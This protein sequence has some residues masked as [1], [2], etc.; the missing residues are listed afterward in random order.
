MGFMKVD[1][2]PPESSFIV[3]TAEEQRDRWIAEKEHF[4]EEWP[5]Y[6]NHGDD[7]YP[8][9]RELS[10]RHGSLQF[11]I[12]DEVQDIAVARGRTTPFC[13]DGT[14]DDLPTGMDA[15]ALRIDQDEPANTLSALAAEVAA[16]HRNRGLSALVIQVMA[17]LAGRAHLSS[18]VAPVRPNWKDRYPLIPIE[19][20][21]Q[22]RRS[23]GLPFDPW[24][25]VHSRLGATI[26]RHEQRSMGIRGSVEEWEGWTEMS[27]PED[28][29]YTFPF[30]LAPLDVKD[31]QGSYWEPNVWMQHPL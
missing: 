18:F 1:C 11:L 26:L 21:A 16:E 25:R 29:T 28:G 20:Y 22:W 8:L 10:L 7:S 5:E 15:L 3:I 12:V 2:L 30:G 9:F 13:W 6:N 14:L 19:Q 27:F 4:D 17:E 31:G 24:M 23:D